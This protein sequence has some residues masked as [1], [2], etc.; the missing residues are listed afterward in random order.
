MSN[1]GG[2]THAHRL[3]DTL[4][5]EGLETYL[6]VRRGEGASWRRISLDLLRDVELDI[7]PDTLRLWYPELEKQPRAER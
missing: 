6:K 3:A 5:P 1:S 2:V 7:H 4:L